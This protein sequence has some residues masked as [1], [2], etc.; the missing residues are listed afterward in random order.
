M[1]GAV[2]ETESFRR[3]DVIA[4]PRIQT[5]A[6]LSVK[7]SEQ[8]AL[9]I[10]WPRTST[11]LDPRD[12][13]RASIVGRLSIAEHTFLLTGDLPATEEWDLHPGSIDVLKVGH[14]GSK[15]STSEVL[16]TEIHPREAIISVGA[17]NRYGHPAPD[18]LNRLNQHGIS[19]LR[20]DQNGTITYRCP[21]T[22]E[23]C[24]FSQ[25]H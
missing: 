9:D 7:L 3:L 8:T 24:T 22:A 10:L 23:A 13:N 11:P 5:R 25:E 15:S 21:E 18:I 16:L 6:G 2:A 17:G 12:T 4:S 1:T 19:I 20:T 14:H